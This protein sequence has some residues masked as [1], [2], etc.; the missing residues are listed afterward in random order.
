M[1]K[2][3]TFAVML[4]LL[5]AFFFG[6]STPLSK[7]LISDLNPFLLAGLLYLGAGIGLSV[8]TLLRGGRL[9]P[10][11]KTLKYK[12]IVGMT[13]FGGLLGPVLLLA[14][15]KIAPAAS[16]AIW[17]N[18]ELVATAILGHFLFKDHLDKRGWLSVALSLCAG[19]L[20]SYSGGAA[21]FT[22]GLLVALAC[23][24]WGFDNHFTA[25]IDDLSPVQSTIIKGLA[26]GTTNLLVGLALAGGAPAAGPVGKA[27]L[28]GFLCY[29]LSITFYISAAQKLG[30]VRSQLIFSLAPLFGVLL[31][32][33]FLGESLSAA[34]AVSG[35]L[36]LASVWLMLAEKHAHA[37]EHQ[38]TEHTHQHTHSDLHHDHHGG[39]REKAHTH[40]HKHAAAA[41]AHPHWPDLHHRHDH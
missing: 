30:A 17:L 32:V 27:L 12:Y 16:V 35:G 37:H 15:V 20:L 6:V 36:L 8:Y 21:G 14:A 9:M 40:H 5:A 26:A 19:L 18:L 28:V 3:D 34:Q 7:A 39:A 11:P 13:V 22:A 25:L 1:K 41:H 23:F 31:A 2:I 38:E 29:G 4:G 33:L 24:S 10:P